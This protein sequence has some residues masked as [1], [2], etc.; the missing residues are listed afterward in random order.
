MLE[1]KR[2]A[3]MHILRVAEILALSKLDGEHFRMVLYRYC[4]K[5]TLD[6]TA[7]FCKEC[8]DKSGRLYINR[9]SRERVRQRERDLFKRLRKNLLT[10]GVIKYKTKKGYFLQNSLYLFI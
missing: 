9:V 6:E 2:D 8:L 7:K 4:N 3:W 5:M 1:T 10:S